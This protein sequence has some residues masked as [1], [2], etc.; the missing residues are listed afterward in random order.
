MRPIKIKIIAYINGKIALKREEPR[1]FGLLSTKVTD[2]D[3]LSSAQ[4]ML[5]KHFQVKVDL[6]DLQTIGNEETNEGILQLIHYDVPMGV[7]LKSLQKG[8]QW[9]H[10]TNLYQRMKQDKCDFTFQND[11]RQVAKTLFSWQK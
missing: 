5:R 10:H 4:Q 7:Y 8:Q 2:D 1:R 6:N 9:E 3:P 11:S